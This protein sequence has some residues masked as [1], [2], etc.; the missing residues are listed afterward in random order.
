MFFGILI[1]LKI[2]KKDVRKLRVN[3][4]SSIGLQ[5]STTYDIFMHST[6]D[7]LQIIST[8]EINQIL[9]ENKSS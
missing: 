4:I 6:I 2:H 1:S 5:I 3:H 8:I 9:E 7:F